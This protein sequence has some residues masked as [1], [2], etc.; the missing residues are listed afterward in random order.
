VAFL[1]GY[2]V[3][4]LIVIQTPS[5]LRD[6]Y[7]HDAADTIQ[8]ALATRI[9]Y[10]PKDFSDAEEISKE[11]G[12]MT[13]KARSLSKPSVVGFDSKGKRQRSVSVSDQRRALLL[14]QEVQQIGRERQ[15]VFYEG[16]RPLLCHKSRYYRERFFRK[17]LFPPPVRGVAPPVAPATNG[18]PDAPSA[19]APT[20]EIIDD[21]FS[22][23]AKP[24][25][26]RRGKRGAGNRVE[27]P[28]S[29]D[30]GKPRTREAT[31]ADIERIETLTLDDFAADFSQVTIP[32]AD[33]LSE[34]DLQVAVESFLSTLHE[35]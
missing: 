13:V 11:L 8:K 20:P 25:R 19:V 24:P 31:V 34:R 29:K 26:S 14:P 10:A 5:Q 18:K 30:P 4:V 21:S 6:V 9:V 28:A 35:R 27:D 3:R 15:I 22:K 7:G 16:L 33:R 23:A 2:N 32:D 17:R 12:N 1:P